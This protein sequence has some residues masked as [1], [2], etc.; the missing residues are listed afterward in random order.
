M[1]YSSVS[2]KPRK[3]L[4][5]RRARKWPLCNR[6]RNEFPDL[7]FSVSHTTR[8][9]RP[10]EVDGRE[11]HFIDTPTFEEMIRLGASC[12]F[13]TFVEPQKEWYVTTSRASSVPGASV[14]AAR[15]GS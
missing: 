8:K 15:S 6:L 1:V 13:S 5:S 11:Y 7:R 10:T 9:P 14:I 3:R 4:C 2:H 12:R